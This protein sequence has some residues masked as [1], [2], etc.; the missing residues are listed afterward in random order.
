M[1]SIQSTEGQEVSSSMVG[2]VNY[3][4]WL[5]GPF[6]GYLVDDLRIHHHQ[7]P[8]H[9]TNR[10]TASSVHVYHERIQHMGAK[11]YGYIL[12]PI[13][14]T[15][16]FRILQ[17]ACKAAV[18]G[19]LWISTDSNPMNL[20]KQTV[21][22]YSIKDVKSKSH[23]DQSKAVSVD[24]HDNQKYY[25]EFH[26]KGH[27]GKIDMLVEWKL[28]QEYKFKSIPSSYLSLAF[29]IH[30]SNSNPLLSNNL[31]SNRLQSIGYTKHIS[32]NVTKITDLN[33]L[34]ECELPQPA[35]MKPWHSVFYKYESAIFPYD[36]N[37]YFNPKKFLSD[38]KHFN[39]R[40]VPLTVSNYEL[41][42]YTVIG[43]QLKLLKDFIRKHLINN[44]NTKG[45]CW[46][47]T[48]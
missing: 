6:V 18:S 28:P 14:G 19:E 16:Q 10:R 33:I 39:I 45:R 5:C 29:N 41:T 11:V 17:R 36:N 43:R 38:S 21:F 30:E 4:E 13:T 8:N 12:P 37:T 23:N 24:L 9:P 46:E 25:F 44:K 20:I 42:Q 34:P 48:I 15:Y 22:T 3:D 7:W 47:Y 26:V 1:I 2:S 40:R 35:P 31:P 32:Y 27:K